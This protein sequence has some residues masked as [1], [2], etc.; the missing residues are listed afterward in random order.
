M[1]SGGARSAGV[2][3]VNPPVTSRDRYGDFPSE[4]SCLPPLGIAGLA[5]AVREASIPVEILDCTALRLDEDRALE[6]VLASP[7]RYVGFS[8]TTMSIAS[9]ASLAKRVSESDVERVVLCGGTHVNAAPDRT[10]RRFPFVDYGFVGEAEDSLVEFLRREPG[11]RPGRS[12]VESVDGILFRDGDAVHATGLR[13]GLRDMDRLPF[14]AW[15]LLPDL[16]GHY[17]PA[18]N[19]YKALPTGSIVTSRGCPEKCAFCDT[20]VAGVRIRGFSPDYM[21]E[22]IRELMSRYGIREIMFHDDVFTLY[23][24]RCVEFC[25]KVVSEGLR[26]SFSCISRVDR[27]DKDLLALLAEAGCWQIAYGIESGSPR[28]LEFLKKGT[29]LDRVREVL[30]WTREAG[31]RTRGYVMLGVPTE[32]PETIARTIDFIQEVDLDDFHCSYF[33]PMPG[34]ALATEARRFGEYDDDWAKMS[35]WVPLFLPWGLSR[36]DLETAH[37][38]M[39]REFYFRPRVAFRYMRSL[40]RP[41]VFWKQAAAGWKLLKY[42]ARSKTGAARSAPA[43]GEG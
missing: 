5:A 33:T 7:H 23:R 26:F 28:V 19:S 40:A 32:T 10:M 13:P 36:E 14:P 35:G 16:P 41:R 37:R 30:A 29:D 27:V 12:G 21:I 1:P 42:T 31:I 22:M 11:R 24:K 25:E 20:S 34:T 17:R 18:P 6:R 39:F 15:D 9:A 8:A 4:G 3:L 38:R 2:L 43:L